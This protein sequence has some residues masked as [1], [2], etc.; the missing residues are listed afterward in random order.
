MP[1]QV[2]DPPDIPPPTYEEAIQPPSYNEA[3]DQRLEVYVHRIEEFADQSA[4]GSKLRSSIWTKIPHFPAFQQN[5][6]VT[7]LRPMHAKRG[8]RGGSGRVEE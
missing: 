3:H 6:R 7:T 2:M 1:L 4:L 8:G 5:R